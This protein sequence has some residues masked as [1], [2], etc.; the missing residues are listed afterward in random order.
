MEQQK[1]IERYRENEKKSLGET[2]WAIH[3]KSSRK[4]Q[5]LKEEEIDVAKERNKEQI[6]KR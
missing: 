4:K 6:K 3:K 5:N 1:Q 2:K